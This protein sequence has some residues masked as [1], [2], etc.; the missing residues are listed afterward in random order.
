ML[1]MDVLESTGNILEVAVML[2]VSIT[3][4][5]TW[6]STILG[7]LERCDKA[8]KTHKQKQAARMLS[9]ASGQR[10]LVSDKS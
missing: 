8:I 6:T 7:T 3:T 10:M 9:L 4:E 1:D 5:L 2:E